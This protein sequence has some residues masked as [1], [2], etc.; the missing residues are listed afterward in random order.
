MKVERM[1][2]C[3]HVL[4]ILFYSTPSCPTLLPL[5][6]F[7]YKRLMDSTRAKP[8]DYS[9]FSSHFI[10]YCFI[11][12]DHE[13]CEEQTTPYYPLTQSSTKYLIWLVWTAYSVWIFQIW[14]DLEFS[15]GYVDIIQVFG[16][17]FG[18][19][20][21]AFGI[22]VLPGDFTAVLQSVISSCLCTVSSVCSTVRTPTRQQS[23]FSRLHVNRNLRGVFMFISRVNS[24]TGKL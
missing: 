9:S 4:F 23:E 12:S 3:K 17:F 22:C 8:L 15:V 5:F 6:S 2:T 1:W 18:L 13:L 7:V 19:A 11:Q 20:Y 24:F 10:N 21:S 16:A 14:P